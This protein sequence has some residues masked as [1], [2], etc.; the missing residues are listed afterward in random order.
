MAMWVQMIRTRPSHSVIELAS[1]APYRG[2]LGHTEPYRCILGNMKFASSPTTIIA[3]MALPSALSLSLFALACQ[4]AAPD[5]PVSREERLAGPWRKIEGEDLIEVLP[6]DG[7]PAIDDPVYVSADEAEEFLVPGET[8]LGVVGKNGTARAYS[9]WH[10]DR[11]EI[12]NDDLDGEPIA[13]T[14]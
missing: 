12:V 11:H 3:R 14:W 8:V 13:A 7:I 4:T 1:I 6:R 5:K 2:R 9:A 10:L